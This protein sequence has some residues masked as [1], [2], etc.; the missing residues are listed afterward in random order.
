M[1]K[2][3]TGQLVA[4]SKTKTIQVGENGPYSVL[5][6][7][8]D[9]YEK[10]RIEV[11]GVDA[12]LISEDI[13]GFNNLFGTDLTLEEAKNIHRYVSSDKIIGISCSFDGKGKFR[14]GIVKHNES[15]PK[16]F[17]TLD[18]A[19]E[20]IREKAREFPEKSMSDL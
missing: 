15:E 16:H 3:I 1:S 18:E 17:K 19:I 4:D 12:P 13:E 10:D 2:V 14:V 8:F 20:K 6:I 9:P 5:A 7:L 11:F